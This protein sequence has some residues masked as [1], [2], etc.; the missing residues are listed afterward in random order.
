MFIEKT[1]FSSGDK[2]NESYSYIGISMFVKKY[3][4]FEVFS[5]IFLFLSLLLD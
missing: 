2:D 4:T 3:K 5:E 1:D